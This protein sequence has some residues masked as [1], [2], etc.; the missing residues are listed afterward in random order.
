[1]DLTIEIFEKSTNKEPIMKYSGKMAKS[2]ANY[3]S[4]LMGKVTL[5]NSNV[6]LVIDNNQKL[7][8]FKRVNKDNNTIN[9]NSNSVPYSIDS[10]LLANSSG[11]YLVNNE[12]VKIIQ[13][14]NKNSAYSKIEISI[15]P[16]TYTMKQIIFYF[17]KYAGNETATEKVVINY[18]N[19]KM[20]V[21]IP[22]SS[23]SEQ[24]FIHF[25]KKGVFVTNEYKGYKL[26][27]QNSSANN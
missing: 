3:Y 22:N 26:I 25:S 5:I 1:M 4:E 20:D 6:N 12:K 17:K 21:D 8:L 23:F 19:I 13:V 11:K 16:I 2:N 24:K 10:T 7:I 14:V 9:K 18:K 27:D 15:D